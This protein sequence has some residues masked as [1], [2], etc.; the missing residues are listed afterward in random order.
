M[1]TGVPPCCLDALGA[2]E[3]VLVSDNRCMSLDSP[4]SSA[5]QPGPLQRLAVIWRSVPRAALGNLIAKLL[6]VS[7]GL[8]IT[9]LVARQGPVV[10]GAFA[11][12]VN[13]VFYFAVYDLSGGRFERLG[14]WRYHCLSHLGQPVPPPA[15]P[16]PVG[17]ATP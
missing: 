4:R 9:V 2:C 6:M 7:L 1:V 5:P 3:C 11:L 17:G 15:V 8:A 14:T 10:Q 16:Q 12:F 13:A